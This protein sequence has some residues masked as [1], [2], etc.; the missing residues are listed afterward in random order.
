MIH[1]KDQGDM[2]EK[3]HEL[4]DYRLNRFKARLSAMYP[5]RSSH[6]SVN[7]SRF[8]S[9]TMIELI[10]YLDTQTQLRLKSVNR[11]FHKL[12]I[13]S[14]ND[15]S[16]SA[17]AGWFSVIHLSSFL[18]RIR[19]Y[20]EPKERELKDF[21]TMLVN[22]GFTEL[23]TIELYH[24][25]EWAMLEIIE[26]LSQRVQRAIRFGI[27][28]DSKVL[29]LV[30]QE[31]EITPFF[32]SKLAKIINTVLFRVLSRIK[33]IVKS[34]EGIDL[35]LTSV[36][37]TKCTH[38]IEVDFSSIPLLRH[39]F[40]LLVNS[41]WNTESNSPSDCPR[42]QQLRLSNTGLTDPCL[43][44]LVDITS[45]GLLSNLVLF[46]LSDNCLTNDGMEVLNSLVSPYLCPNLHS[47]ILSNN[48]DIGGEA[49][50][51]FFESL[52]QGV[53]PVIED[54]ALHN[55]GMN[56]KNMKA[57]ASFLLTPFA[58][59]LKSID[60]G[61]NPGVSPNMVRF[62]TNLAQSRCFHLQVINVEGIAFTKESERAFVKWVLNGYL[63]NLRCLYL[64]NTL[65]DQRVFCQ[66]FKALTFSSIK[67][68]DILD[69]SSNLIGSFQDKDWELLV[70]EAKQV[71][72]HSFTIRRFEFCH[73][74]LN[75]NDLDW[76]CKCIQR[77]CCVELLQ[78]ACF[79]DNA[80]SSRGLEAFL[81]IFP[82]NQPSGLIKLSVITL[83]LRC[84]GKD[85]YYW[86]CSPASFN[87]RRLILTNCNM[88]SQD[89]TYLLN[90]LEGG[91]P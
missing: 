47:I 13:I 90:A 62:W 29:N 26:A 60:I 42:I 87:L 41:I 33:F 52:C 17:R 73:N 79:E 54:I 46:D 61:N 16:L 76:L 72:Q 66:F 7:V 49:L 15:V 83:S 3:L 65:F 40:E 89:L 11:Y 31:T 51:H 69:L 53:C 80:I 19:L 70:Y 86:L 6:G 55:C 84:I 10:S 27:L 37:F 77:F 56:A 8:R 63:E 35:V 82:P 18:K 64:N 9:T 44:F 30:I 78:E 91:N 71:N 57:F 68:L 36:L 28:D 85:L 39:G 74:P 38:L 22:D 4:Y 59:N 81:S 20:G 75:N 5:Q 58:E 24:I 23:D 2:R 45:Q 32:A 43:V 14:H 25:G 12:I 48:C 1:P 34:M 21:T 88:C 50:T 67:D